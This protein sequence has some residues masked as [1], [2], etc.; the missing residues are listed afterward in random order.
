MDIK[1]KPGDKVHRLA[2][3]PIVF[4]TEQEDVFKQYGRDEDIE[5]AYREV[6]TTSL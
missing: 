1:S 4:L 5:D 2:W 6:I 3:L